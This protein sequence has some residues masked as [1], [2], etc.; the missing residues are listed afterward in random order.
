MVLNSDV[1]LLLWLTGW[2]RERRKG[3]GCT[4]GDHMIN[5]RTRGEH[6]GRCK[7]LDV[8]SPLRCVEVVRS[9]ATPGP[10]AAGPQK[11]KPR[12]SGQL[13]HCSPDRKSSLFIS[14]CK[15]RQC[16]STE[17]SINLP[18]Q[19]ISNFNIKRQ[20]LR[21]RQRCRVDDR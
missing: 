3:A 2:F 6:E 16:C 17:S 5:V 18:A 13:P 19:N 15:N 9:E 21:V 12:G 4:G 10:R 7:D 1:I 11:K 14:G 8:E 20:T